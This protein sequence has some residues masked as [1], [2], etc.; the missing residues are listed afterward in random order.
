MHSKYYR[1]ASYLMGDD[2][3]RKKQKKNKKNGFMMMSI[4]GIGTV[5]QVKFKLQG[6]SFG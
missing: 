6:Q 1:S 4:D 3:R 2:I 5:C